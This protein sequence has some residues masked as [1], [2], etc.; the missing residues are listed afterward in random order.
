MG[1]V[2]TQN[3]TLNESLEMSHD[4]IKNLNKLYPQYNKKLQMIIDS[5]P[6]F[7]GWHST[8]KIVN[9]DLE[10]QV[11]K[12]KATEAQTEVFKYAAEKL[13]EVLLAL[14][15]EIFPKV[16]TQ[17]GIVKTKIEKLPPIFKSTEEA[18]KKLL[19]KFDDLM[20]PEDVESWVTEWESA[21]SNLEEIFANAGISFGMANDGMSDDTKETVEE[22]NVYWGNLTTDLGRAYGTLFLEL[23]NKNTTFEESFEIFGGRLVDSF[24]A[25]IADMISD[26][27]T[28]FLQEMIDG[29]KKPVK[30][31]LQILPLR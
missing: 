17:S 6:F 31:L 28:G 13:N 3:E 15:I 10:L 16:S 7:K 18:V 20:E 29:S 1:G 27:V 9:A 19:E 22:I 21:E 12:M 11:A 23:T 24:R 4:I 26:W 2:I 30:K 5:I 14:G 8:L 25:T